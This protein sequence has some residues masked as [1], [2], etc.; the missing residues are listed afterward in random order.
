VLEHTVPFRLCP[1]DPFALPFLPQPNQQ[2]EL[3]LP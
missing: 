3:F 1:V 2:R